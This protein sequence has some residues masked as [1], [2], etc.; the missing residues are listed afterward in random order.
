MADKS[1]DE[2]D[3]MS[4]AFLVADTRPGLLSREASRKHQQSVKI[5]EKNAKYKT[6]PKKQLEQEKRTEGLEKPIGSENKGFALLQK[7]GYK[8]GMAI[9][10]KGS[11]SPQ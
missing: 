7:M 5:K 2:D 1:S 10:K 9:G 6:I 8:P 3:Y 11:H 4:D